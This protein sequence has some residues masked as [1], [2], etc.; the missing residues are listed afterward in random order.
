MKDH[1]G[2]LDQPE[3][4]A[5]VFAPEQ[6]MSLDSNR[7]V[8]REIGDEVVILDVPTATYLNLNGS[9]RALWKRLDVGTTPSE[10][11]AELVATYAIPVEQAATDVAAFLG[12]LSKRSLL[13]L[14][15]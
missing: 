13:S 11:V 7:A 9:G 8:W 4:R 12:E 14:P 10:L 2:E 6:P 1:V 15:A 3:E 5:S